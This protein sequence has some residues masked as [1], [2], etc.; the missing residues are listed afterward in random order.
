MADGP[1]Q[2]QARSRPSVAA[3]I[4]AYNEEA[5]V[6]GVVDTAMSAGL[7]DEVIVV[8]NGSTDATADV[9]AS[10]GARV[11]EHPEGGKGHAMAAG[12]AATDADVIVF[13]D[14]DLTGLTADH[15][16]RLVAS[17]TMGGAG[18]S[19]GLFDR[20]SVQN[21][22]FLHALPRLTGQRA[23]HRE[24]F[25]S[26]DPE[27]IEGYRVEAALNNR[28]RELD[29]DIDA[30]VLEGMFHRTKEEK[31]DTPAKGWAKKIAML[32]TA[33]GAYLAYWTIRRRRR[34]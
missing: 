14:A 3:I 18:M 12:V 28:A 19:L 32:G 21:R 6:G 10:R 33:M 1:P 20:G 8:D 15:V 34:G 23:M 7:T 31:L 24:L 13:L 29:I 11:V 17:V 26:L 25:E 9:A 22:V 27:D 5:T 2:R 16:D 4:P 30:F